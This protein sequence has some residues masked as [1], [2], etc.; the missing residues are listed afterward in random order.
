MSKIMVRPGLMAAALAIACT[1]AG[2]A[3]GLEGTDPFAAQ[4]ERGEKLYAARC[5]ACH[6]ANLEGGIGFD[7]VGIGP[8]YRWIGQNAE[9]LYQ[10]VMAMP[11]GAPQSLPTQDYVDLT[12]F[13]I[14]RNGGK[15]SAALAADPASLRQ[16]P[17]GIVEAGLAKPRL[18]MRNDISKAIGGGPNQDELNLADK[19]DD[20]W[21]QPN[22]DYTGHRFAD[23][24]KIDR[25]NV[26]S[27][28]PACL[29]QAGDVSPFATSPLVYR[30]ALFFTTR[31]SAISIDAVTCR[32]N[33]RYDRPSR[34]PVG[35]GLKINRGAAIK[36]GK[37]VF[38]THDGFLVALDAGTGKTVWERDVVNPKENQGGFTMPPV[39][40]EDLVIIG[41]AGSE[42]GARG[43]IG[44]FRLSTGEPVWRF[45]TIPDDDEPGADSWPN[46][47][48]RDHGGGTVWGA[49]TVDAA[50]G[51][52]F[53]PVS[54][55]A[56]AFTG[57]QRAGANLY[58]S[59]MVVLDIHTGK[60]AWYYQV[61][62]HD[63]HD[64][65]V[66]H[67]GPQFS[68]TVDGKRRDLVVV[69]GK[70]GLMQVMD[71]D[72]HKPLYAVQIVKRQNTE[73]PWT[74]VDM[75]ETGAKVCPGSFGGI[76]WDGP[77]FN[78]GTNMLYVPSVEW[79]GTT[80]Q[81]VDQSRGFLT[82]TDAS[83]GAIKWRYESQ[84]PMLAAVTTTSS[85]LV[86]TGEL[87][88]D[89]L[90]LDAATG[91]IL[92]RYNL[93][94]PLL[95]GI[96]TYRIDDVQYVA[97]TTGS[98]SNFWQADPASSTIVVFALPKP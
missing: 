24:G 72:T 40:F 49:V 98:A 52:I 56:P 45:N 80:T 55:P 31:Y 8:A 4:S 69:A 50:K 10:R 61:S 33:W 25:T 28:R 94:G 91:K 15:S 2:V 54:N 19:T 76:E 34:V 79:C 35:Y 16:V 75:S 47:S 88:G 81:P 85:G 93:G 12:A 32:L 95:G 89:F 62:P 90:A 17:I 21:L 43:W 44:A 30:G 46:H 27:L 37:L 23:I 38:G 87:T 66:T 1:A 7:L 84:R 59:S 78:P 68:A 41:P 36:D 22:R 51:L 9:D 48:V 26:R 77:A 58:T 97:A 13:I 5:A 73:V 96:V 65:D 39:I 86:F 42:L 29:Y 70:E 92:L 3:Q 11:K 74:A 14:A 20:G 57:V 53:V 63:T 67:A 64:Y 60:L 82:A 6:G 71:R 83:T 18:T